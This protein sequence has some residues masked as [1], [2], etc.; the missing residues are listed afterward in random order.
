MLMTILSRNIH[1][2]FHGERHTGSIQAV[3][4]Q[5]ETGT[6]SQQNQRKDSR[7]NETHDSIFYIVI[8]F[9]VFIF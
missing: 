1:H 2:G 6:G 5:Q 4:R 9:D 7:N 8:D 3:I